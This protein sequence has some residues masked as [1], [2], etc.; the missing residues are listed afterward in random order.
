MTSHE[1]HKLRKTR[2]KLKKFVVKSKSTYIFLSYKHVRNKVNALNRKLK[3]EYYTKQINEN[4]G[5]T[6]QTWKIINEIVNLYILRCLYANFPAAESAWR[7]TMGNKGRTRG[8]EGRA[9]Q[10]RSV[11]PRKSYGQVHSQPCSRCV[12]PDWPWLLGSCSRLP[13]RLGFAFG[14]LFAEKIELFP[15]EL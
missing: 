9:F 7:K 6:K 3:N 8:A 14:L 12:S 10:L 5:N 13:I 11:G 4:L 1:Y 2:D 15:L